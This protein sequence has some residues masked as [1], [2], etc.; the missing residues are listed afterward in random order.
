MAA[1]EQLLPQFGILEQLAIERDPD[2]APLVGDRL[3][4]AREVDDREPPG[5]EDHAGLGVELLVVGSAVGDGPGHGEEAARG[6]LAGPRQVDGAGDSAH[7]WGV[8]RD[9]GSPPIL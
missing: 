2:V 4:A 8:S 9:G 7:A 6:E 5:A 3:A 1:G